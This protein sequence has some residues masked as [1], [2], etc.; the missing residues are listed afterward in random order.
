MDPKAATCF[1]V[2]HL[3]ITQTRNVSQISKGLRYTTHRYS[4]TLGWFFFFFGLHWPGVALKHGREHVE[5]FLFAF[6]LGGHRVV[7]G[8][9]HAV[10][11][12]SLHGVRQNLYRCNHIHKAVLLLWTQRTQRASARAGGTPTFSDA[13]EII[14]VAFHNLLAGCFPLVRVMF[15]HHCFIC[16]EV[17]NTRFVWLRQE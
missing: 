8:G 4:V 3:S 13:G 16:R 5:E 9:V 11:R 7:E 6:C 17:R 14:I 15:Q 1:L 10:E 2:D 12:A